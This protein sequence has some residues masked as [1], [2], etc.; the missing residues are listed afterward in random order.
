[1]SVTSDISVLRW[2]KSSDMAAASRPWA[3]WRAPWRGHTNCLKRGTPQGPRHHAGNIT[4]LSRARCIAWL[5]VAM[6]LKSNSV[7]MT[8]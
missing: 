4:T 3:P 7:D 5:A 8:V 1:M 2:P 6:A